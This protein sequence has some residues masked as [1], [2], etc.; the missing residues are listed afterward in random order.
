MSLQPEVT[1]AIHRGQHPAHPSDDLDADLAATSNAQVT[2]LLL[3]DGDDGAQMQQRYCL[4]YTSPL[5][6]V[7]SAWA[8]GHG[9]P[10][11]AVG[12]EASNGRQVSV[13]DSP[14][15]LGWTPGSEYTLYVVPLDEV[16]CG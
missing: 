1:P 6:E 10:Q 11:E 5:S 16:F 8:G 4:C 13:T 2:V 12:L 14:E 3:A 7:A 15:N 9:V